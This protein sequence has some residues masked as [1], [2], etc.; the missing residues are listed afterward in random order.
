M[1][2][3]HIAF[4]AQMLMLPVGSSVLLPGRYYASIETHIPEGS[5]VSL[6][7]LLSFVYTTLSQK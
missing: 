1:T 6:R 3:Y 4:V 5:A 2:L 7:R